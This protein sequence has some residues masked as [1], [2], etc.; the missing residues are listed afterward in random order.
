MYRCLYYDHHKSH[1]NG[2]FEFNGCLLYYNTF[3][4]VPFGD[5]KVKILQACY[6]L[7]TIGH[8]NLT[9][10]WSWYLEIIGGHECRSL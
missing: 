6:D 10:L 8:S 7:P 1:N 3:L 9:R 5:L 2:D 4:C